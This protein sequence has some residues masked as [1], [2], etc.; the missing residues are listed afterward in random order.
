MTDLPADLLDKPIPTDGQ[1][2]ECEDCRRHYD[3]FTESMNARFAYVSETRHIHASTVLLSYYRIFH[4]R[5]HV[6]GQL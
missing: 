3:M 6:G 4:M 1:L 5:G 2:A